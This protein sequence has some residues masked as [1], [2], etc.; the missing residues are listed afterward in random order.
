MHALVES[1]VVTLKS[2][3]EAWA[4]FG[5]KPKAPSSNSTAGP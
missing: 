3:S 2:R 1:L 4:G 5:A